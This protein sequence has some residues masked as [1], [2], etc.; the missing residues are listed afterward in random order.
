MFSFYLFILSGLVIATMLVAKRVG[1]RKKTG[2]FFL[3]IISRGD[4]RARELHHQAIHQYSVN[5]ERAYLLVT[6]QMPIRARNYWNKFQVQ[7]REAAEKYSGDIR[8]S[9]LLKRSDGISEFFKNISDIEKGGEINE[10]YEDR[11]S[12]VLEIPKKRVPRK[13]KVAVVESE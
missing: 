9:R 8:N 12:V 11:E 10:V 7:V 4:E 5:K 13:K 2:V 3:K 1:E 6:K